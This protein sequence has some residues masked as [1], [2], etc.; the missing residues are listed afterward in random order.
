MK[1]ATQ[2][3]KGLAALTKRRKWPIPTEGMNNIHQE[4]CSVRFSLSLHAHCAQMQRVNQKRVVLSTRPIS[5]VASTI[6]FSFSY[7]HLS[8]GS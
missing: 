4:E 1:I 5:E 8:F 7:L 2:P 6:F 3:R